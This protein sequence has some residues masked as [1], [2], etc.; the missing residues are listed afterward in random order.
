MMFKWLGNTIYVDFPWKQD[1]RMREEA[2]NSV[3]AEGS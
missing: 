1:Q 2:L 3:A